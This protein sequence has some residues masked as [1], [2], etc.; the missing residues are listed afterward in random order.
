[1][2]P[3]TSLYTRVS[4]VSSTTRASHTDPEEQVDPIQEHKP[5]GRYGRRTTYILEACRLDFAIQVS[6]LEYHRSRHACEKP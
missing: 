4:R 5:V 1:M 2:L 6:P 3:L